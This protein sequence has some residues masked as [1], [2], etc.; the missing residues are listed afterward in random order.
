MPPRVCN[1]YV[2]NLLHG[3]LGHAIEHGHVMGSHGALSFN[4]KV[5]RGH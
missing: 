3:S 5:I 1:I 2:G 4:V